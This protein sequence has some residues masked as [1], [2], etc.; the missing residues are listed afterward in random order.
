MEQTKTSKT[1]IRKV[2]VF[3][4]GGHGTIGQNP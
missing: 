2:A 3:L 4:K 1:K